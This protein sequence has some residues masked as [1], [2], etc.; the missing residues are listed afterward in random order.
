M[1][2]ISGRGWDIKNA[3]QWKNFEAGLI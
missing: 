2:A 1:K 3:I